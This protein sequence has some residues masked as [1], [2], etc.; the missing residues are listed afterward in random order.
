MSIRNIHY[1]LS[2]SLSLHLRLTFTL[3]LS[4]SL[5][6][7]SPLSSQSHPRYYFDFEEVEAELDVYGNIQSTIKHNFAEFQDA[8]PRYTRRTVVCGNKHSYKSAEF[9][10]YPVGRLFLY[11]S[12]TWETPD[13]KGISFNHIEITLDSAL[14]PHSY[15]RISFLIANMK[16][17]RYKPAHYGVKFS[18]DKV[19]KEGQGSLMSEPDIFFDFTDD[20]AFVEIQAILFFEEPVK[21]LYFGM[22]NEDST[23][24]PKKFNRVS[25]KISYSDTAAYYQYVKP[26]R[27]M[28]DNILLERL[29]TMQATFRDIH[30]KIDDDQVKS[31]TDIAHIKTIASTM[32]NYPDTYLLIHGY[33]D[34]SGT[35][36]YNLDLSNRR[37]AHVK[38]ILVEEGIDQRRIVTIGRGKM[39]VD[40]DGSD[41][42]YARKVSFLL[43]Q[44]P[45]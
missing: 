33:A 17:H 45:K 20:D 1:F 29:D 35:Y 7:I 3:R 41:P 18:A 23:R 15:Y 43:L 12:P 22:F 34:Q 13:K 16:S 37:A 24:V 8:V 6:C 4:L 44:A 19:I 11:H 2:L 14:T 40:G 30:Y 27:I 36:L 5:C 38:A 42:G 10:N 9:G 21:Y 32:R 28:L 39:P 25:D 26:T 31:P